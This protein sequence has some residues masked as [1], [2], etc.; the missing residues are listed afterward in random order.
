MDAILALQL[1]SELHQEFS[2]LLHDVHVAYVDLKAPF[3]SVDHLALWKALR[4]V[5]VPG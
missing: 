5:G 4:G 3:D 2:H 1:L